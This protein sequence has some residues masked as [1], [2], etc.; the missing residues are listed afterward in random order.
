[1]QDQEALNVF[2]FYKSIFVGGLSSMRVNIVSLLLINFLT[3]CSMFATCKHVQF[4]SDIF[5]EIAQGNKKAVRTWLKSKPDLS[6]CN[7][8]GQSLLAVAVVT[9]QRDMVKIFIKAG[10][11]INHVDKQGK[12]ALDH[13]VEYGCVKIVC[14]LAKKGAKVTTTDNLYYLKT[15]L[16]EHAFSLIVRVFL[17]YLVA[18]S[19][20]FVIKNIYAFSP[21]GLFVFFP[22]CIIAIPVCA[23]YGS[24]LAVRSCSWYNFSRNNWMLQTDAGMITA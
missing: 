5:Y 6:I 22:I 7:D 24:C 2:R 11:V 8:Q 16:K 19:F 17:L 13:A 1:M 18:T 4:Q 9:G 20:I 21:L 23:I 3:V 12:T 15:V 10:V 14:D